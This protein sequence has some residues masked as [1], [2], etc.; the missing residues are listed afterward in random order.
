M[1]AAR[2]VLLVLT[3]WIAARIAF[4][5]GLLYQL[6]KDGTWAKYD[7]VM[8]TPI[9]GR[10]V[11]VTQ[12]WQLSFV[13]KESDGDKPCRWIEFQIETRIESEFFPHTEHETWTLLIPEA[14]LGKGEAPMEH[15]LRGWHQRGN[16][17][18]EKITKPIP[19]TFWFSPYGFF[20]YWKG[21]QNTRPHGGHVQ[22]RN[23]VV[24]RR[25]GDRRKRTR[26]GN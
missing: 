12:K 23:A 13:G 15:I 25:S 6:P 22:T 2:Q 4:G 17:K 10:D 18:P 8:K 1:S 11:S 3:I 24:R 20:W 26:T 9:D 14:N 21:R 7:V 16:D 19:A 5:D